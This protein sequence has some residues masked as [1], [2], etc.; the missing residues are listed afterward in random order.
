MFSMFNNIVLATTRPG[1]VI[2]C[3][4][5]LTTGHG[6]WRLPACSLVTSFSRVPPVSDLRK[7]ALE[8]GCSCHQR[9]DS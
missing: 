2:Q 7:F 3:Y 9:L 5:C 6:A 1:M 8:S 4:P